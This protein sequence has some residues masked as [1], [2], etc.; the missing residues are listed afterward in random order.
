MTFQYKIIIFSGQNQFS[1]QNSSFF[2]AQFRRKII[3]FQVKSTTSFCVSYRMPPPPA[4]QCAFVVAL[5]IPLL[6][7]VRTALM[8]FS[9]NIRLF[10]SREKLSS[11]IPYIPAPGKMQRKFRPKIRGKL[12]DS[13][14]L[15]ISRSMY[16]RPFWRCNFRVSRSA[17][18]PRKHIGTKKA[19][20]DHESNPLRTAQFSIENGID[21]AIR[22]TH[23]SF[24]CGRPL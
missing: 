15:H 3:I 17:L 18:R 13:V 23:G 6:L 16:Y 2:N 14:P 20:W 22:R 8:F 9:F 12:C 4:P 21:F 7:A 5:S 11:I 24:S 19:H 1:G 10:K